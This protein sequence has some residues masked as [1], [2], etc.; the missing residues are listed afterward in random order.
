M[1]NKVS[2]LLI[3]KFRASFKH[4]MLIQANPKEDQAL[5]KFKLHSV[6]WIINR[7]PIEDLNVYSNV[8]GVDGLSNILC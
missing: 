2:L 5:I 8:V 6:E 4:Q 7:T 1:L 3:C